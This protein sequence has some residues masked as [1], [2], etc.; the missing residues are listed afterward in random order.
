MV[1]SQWGGGGGDLINPGFHL[2]TMMPLL[3]LKMSCFLMNDNWT[4]CNLK[5]MGGGGG[6]GDVI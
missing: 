1:K 2:D 5:M 6:G 4:L 3:C